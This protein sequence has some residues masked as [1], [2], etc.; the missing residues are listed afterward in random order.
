MARI[1]VGNMADLVGWVCG[2]RSL[3]IGTFTH[4]YR[5]SVAPYKFFTDDTA[6][7][8]TLLTHYGRVGDFWRH[9]RTNEDFTGLEEDTQDEQDKCGDVL[10]QGLH[11][12]DCPCGGSQLLSYV[13]RECEPQRSVVQPGL[14]KA[15]AQWSRLSDQYC[16]GAPF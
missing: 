10:L 12:Q 4:A 14:V 15:V 5:A 9:H 2:L 7:I 16:R 3:V 13:H 6:P 1:L 8:G 11:K